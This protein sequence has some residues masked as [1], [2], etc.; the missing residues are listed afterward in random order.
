MGHIEDTETQRIVRVSSVP[1][2]LCGQIPLCL[3]GL[4]TF[5]TAC[6]GTAA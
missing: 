1:L 4:S 6:Q 5:T 2:S 3:A